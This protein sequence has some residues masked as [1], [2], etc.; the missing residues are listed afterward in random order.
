MSSLFLY[1]G[2][3]VFELS[4]F[5]WKSYEIQ[6][7]RVPDVEEARARWK[8]CPTLYEVMG[9]HVHPIIGIVKITDTPCGVMG[10]LLGN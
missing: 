6:L 8:A 7:T 4:E 2:V 5:K 1:W 10:M 9:F 3:Y